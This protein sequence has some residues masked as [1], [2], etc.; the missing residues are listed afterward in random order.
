MVHKKKFTETD[1]INTTTDNNLCE[2]DLENLTTDSCSENFSSSCSTIYSSSV[3]SNTCDYS[4]CSEQDCANIID[5]LKSFKSNN[6]HDKTYKKSI[7]KNLG[8]FYN[9]F[10][11]VSIY[12][13][14]LLSNLFLNINHKIKNS[15]SHKKSYLTSSTKCSTHSKYSNKKSTK[16]DCCNSSS[17][18]SSC[19]KKIFIKHKKNSKKCKSKKYESNNK[20]NLN[21]EIDNLTDKKKDIKFIKNNFD[22]NIFIKKNSKKSKHKKSKKCNFRNNNSPDISC[23]TDIL[24]E[25]YDVLKD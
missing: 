24:N 8:F 13:Y 9:K 23:N 15:Y 16:N 17:S 14:N 12:I 20:I 22:K 7:I 5:D 21:D 10:Y 1:I 11:Y 6:Y 2:N 25:I 4:S 3:M 18:S 19:N